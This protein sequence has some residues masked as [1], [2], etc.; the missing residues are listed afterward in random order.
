MLPQAH[1]PAPTSNQD[2]EDN[3]KRVEIVPEF[4]VSIKQESTKMFKS[5]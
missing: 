2:T 3:H 1:Q 4:Q 5:I